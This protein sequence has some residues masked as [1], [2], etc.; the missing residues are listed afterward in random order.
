MTQ[1]PTVGPTVRRRASALAA[2]GL[3]ALVAPPASAGSET[4]RPGYW[5]SV[6]RVEFPGFHAKTDRRCIT[7]A[8]VAKFIQGPSNHIYDCRYPEHS[9]QAGVI[10]FRGRCVDKR[11][12]T[13]PI[14]GHGTY[15]PDTL[16][17][18]AAVQIGPL[19]VV[20]STQAHRISD[21]CPSAPAPASR[22]R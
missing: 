2:F 9:A 1:R 4:I 16:E 18:T 22:A 8:Q 13:F 20:A 14:S 21:D 10:S 15:A 11:G 3:L 12:R 19:K 7:P 6:N 5:E 17:M